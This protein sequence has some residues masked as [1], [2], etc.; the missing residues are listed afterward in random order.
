MLRK[1]GRVNYEIEVTLEGEKTRKQNSHINMLKKW[2]PPTDENYVN[3]ITDDPGEEIPT[4]PSKSNHQ[5]IRETKVGATLSQSQR[6]DVE[7]LL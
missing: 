5:D 4:I 1:I 7:E 2:H 6:T 3:V